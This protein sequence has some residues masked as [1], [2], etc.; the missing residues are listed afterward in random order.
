MKTATAGANPLLEDTFEC[1]AQNDAGNIY[2]FGEGTTDFL[3]HDEGN[4]S[5]AARNGHG[6]LASMAQRQG[7]S[8]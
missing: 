1:Y 6:K 7:Q 2:Y 3:Y 8:C 5:A 4:P